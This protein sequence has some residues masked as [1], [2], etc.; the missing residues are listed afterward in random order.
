MDKIKGFLKKLFIDGLSGMAL[1]LFAT[2][3]VGTIIQQIGTLIGGNI[4]N[5]IF[6]IGKLGSALMGAG[7]GCLGV[8]HDRSVCGKDPFRWDR[9][10]CGGEPGRSRRA[11]GRL[12]C[13]LCRN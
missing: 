8:R 4:G 1:G 9:R 11:C 3:I 6:T 7:L 2:L 5:L 13:S 12:P 10:R